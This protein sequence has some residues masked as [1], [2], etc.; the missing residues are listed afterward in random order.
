M[1]ILARE[2]AK[3]LANNYP[4][5]QQASCLEQ[6]KKDTEIIIP[7]DAVVYDTIIEAMDVARYSIETPLFQKWLCQAK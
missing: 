3:T 6:I 1:S 2:M 5:D 4:M 7:E